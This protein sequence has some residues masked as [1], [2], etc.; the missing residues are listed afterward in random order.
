MIPAIFLLILLTC[1]PTL[2][3]RMSIPVGFFVPMC[4][5]VLHWGAVSAIC[6]VA[7]I[8]IGIAVFEV[9][10]PIL[11][12]MRRWTWFDQKIWP[13]LASRQEK[14]RP[15]VEKYG[16]WG[17]AIFIGIPLPGTG[18]FSGALGAFL[19]GF[20]RKRFYWANAIGVTIACICVTTFCLLIRYGAISEDSFMRKLFIKDT[21]ALLVAE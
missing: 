14:L 4:T 15:S 1:L 5:D 18:A 6:L 3:L 8:V 10:A 20:S 11:E 21:P 17:L 2:E 16:E 12:I 9:L 19:L 7:N 13:H